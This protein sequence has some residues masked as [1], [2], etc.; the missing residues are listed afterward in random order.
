MGE[1]HLRFLDGDPAYLCGW[2]NRAAAHGVGLVS[3][4]SYALPGHGS[5]VVNHHLI[6]R[7][8]IRQ[9]C[10]F[11]EAISIDDRHFRY[12]GILFFL[13]LLTTID[14]WRV[15]FAKGLACLAV[16]VLGLYGLKNS[17]TGAYAQM[18]AG[19]YDPLTGISQYIVSP[20]ILEYMRSEIT[21]NNF[22]RPIAVVPSPTVGISLP[23]FRILYIPGHIYR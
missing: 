1:N 10:I 9:Q 4:S 21:R 7:A 15:R 8:C 22:R 13:L 17:V 3:T 16:I 23:R 19:Y 14:Q 12:A 11:G 6:V 18:R 2:T 5:C 20:A